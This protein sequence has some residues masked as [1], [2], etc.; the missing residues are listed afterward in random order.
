MDRRVHASSP[1]RCVSALAIDWIGKRG[2]GRASQILFMWHGCSRA[3]RR[4][5]L[6]FPG[7]S[8]FMALTPSRDASAQVR[9]GPEIPAHRSGFSPAPHL[10]WEAG[11]AP[12]FPPDKLHRDYRRE[13]EGVE[14]NER[15]KMRKAAGSES[16]G[17][18]PRD[19]VHVFA[20]QP[21]ARHSRAYPW[22]RR[23]HRLDGIRECEIK[24]LSILAGVKGA[25]TV[26]IRAS[27]DNSTT[28][29]P[30]IHSPAL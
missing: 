3:P 21:D 23:R 13:K 4:L 14:R 25:G 7:P 27:C 15:T 28:C 17:N 24:A 19:P 16:C 26:E 5:T 22:D 18:R 8:P 6:A 12:P 30:S 10:S 2:T 1:P 20:G 29:L 11:C 9:S